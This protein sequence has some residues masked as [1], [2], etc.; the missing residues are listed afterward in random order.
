M[1]VVARRT[2]LRYE[3]IGTVAGGRVKY[4]PNVRPDSGHHQGRKILG[5]AVSTSEIGEAGGAC[6]LAGSAPGHKQWPVAPMRCL[7]PKRKCLDGIAAGQDE[8]RRVGETGRWRVRCDNQKRR[9]YRLMTESPQPVRR[10]RGIW[11]GPGDQNSHRINDRRR[12]IRRGG[13]VRRRHR[14]RA[15]RHRRCRHAVRLR[16]I[17]CRPAPR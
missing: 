16:A 8:C 5:I 2:Q 10:P 17:R 1:D 15:P 12:S 6:R 7:G 9:D 3:R 13:G 11:L 14:P 4:W